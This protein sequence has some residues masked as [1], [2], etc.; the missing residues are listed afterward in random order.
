MNTTT[1][2]EQIIQEIKQGKEINANR[3]LLWNNNQTIIKEILKPFCAFY[4]AQD[5][6]QECY[7]IMQNAID[8]YSLD[9]DYKFTTYLTNSIRWQM[10]R[11]LT[12][13]KG[14]GLPSTLDK[15]YNEY[16]RLIT[17][18]GDI[19]DVRASEMLNISYKQL[20]TIKRYIFFNNATSLDKPAEDDNETL[21]NIIPD[22]TNIAE[23]YEEQNETAT[24]FG[25]YDI[26]Q[27]RL[28]PKEYQVIEYYYKDQIPTNKIAKQLNISETRVHQYRRQALRQLQRD[29]KI[30]RLASEMHYKT[31]IAYKYGF[32]AWKYSGTSAVEKSIEECE[33]IA[34][35]IELL[36]QNAKHYTQAF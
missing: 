30:I 19:S 15:P 16:R 35:R 2:N 23:Q 31:D 13:L 12:R 34:E 21:A 6:L 20:K 28:K 9:S 29:G 10:P 4:E 5:L 25:L 7:I 26:A 3:L 36:L 33:S 8:N 32:N 22:N 11:I 14:F 18:Y 24:S 27:Q 17:K 1:T